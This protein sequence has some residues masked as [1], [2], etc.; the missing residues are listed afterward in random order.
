V[1][2]FSHAGELTQGIGLPDDGRV[3]IDRLGIALPDPKKAP[4]SLF[5]YVLVGAGAEHFALD[6][7]SGELVA[8]DPAQ[9]DV[10]W[11]APVEPPKEIVDAIASQYRGPGLTWACVIHDIHSGA[12]F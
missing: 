1:L 4:G 7:A 8:I 5:E 3:V 6:E 9:D 12:I 11:S 2:Q 10:S